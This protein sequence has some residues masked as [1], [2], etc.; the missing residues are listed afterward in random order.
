MRR[1]AV[2][3]LVVMLLGGFAGTGCSLL[4]TL[5]VGLG[6]SAVIPEDTDKLDITAMVDVFA[7]IDVLQLQIEGS[8]GYKQYQYTEAAGA[9]PVA[10]D[11][12]PVSVTARYVISGGMVRILLGGGLLWNINDFD[13]F[14]G[15]KVEDPLCYRLIVGADL[16]LVSSLKLGLEVS[17]DIAS[18]ADLLAT[19]NDFNS[20]GLLVRLTMG[21]HF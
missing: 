15:L 19:G 9:D 3:A 1:G 12:I 16:A 18:D 13:D 8:V 14:G 20:D 11:Q 6:V 5:N 2:V 7:K 4:P 10:L 21:Y 17:F